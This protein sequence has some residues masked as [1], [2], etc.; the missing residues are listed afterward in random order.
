MKKCPE[1]NQPI[2]SKRKKASGSKKGTPFE[3]EICKEISLWWSWGQ[4]DDLVW[5]TATSGG[6]ATSRFETSE[7]DTQYAFGDLA[8]TH[9]DIYP[10]FDFLLF[11]VKRGYNKTLDVME[12]VDF[13]SHLVKI[14]QIQDWWATAQRDAI[15]AGRPETIIVGKRD[16]RK[17]YCVISTEFFDLIESQHEESFQDP[18]ITIRNE[19][20]HVVICL[21]TDW[22]AYFEPEDLKTITA[23]PV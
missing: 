10:L 16:H 8:P 1:C 11:E 12:E 20:I 22:F 17:N 15:R 4:R 19:K 6:R 9:K 13:P 23:K 7:L 21:F 5:R 2:K 3:R 18:H 14:P